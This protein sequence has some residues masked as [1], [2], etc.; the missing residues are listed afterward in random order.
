MPLA[1]CI[2]CKVSCITRPH[3]SARPYACGR[4]A[5]IPRRVH[6]VTNHWLTNCLPWSLVK[7]LGTPTSPHLAV[8]NSSAA[9]S[10]VRPCFVV[11]HAVILP[12]NRSTL[13]GQQSYGCPSHVVFGIESTSKHT[14]PKTCVGPVS[15]GYLFEK[16]TSGVHKLCVSGI[17]D[18]LDQPW[19]ENQ[20]GYIHNP[21]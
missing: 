1:Q 8:N 21:R 15:D 3:T 13:S 16:R 14:L 10:P 20:W 12:V 5:L 7:M 4:C 9:I 18:G 11:G 2:L 19:N 6:K 17:A